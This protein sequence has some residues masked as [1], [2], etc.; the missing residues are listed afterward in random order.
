M[1][2]AVA[3]DLGVGGRLFDKSKTSQCSVAQRPTITE[4]LFVRS[5]VSSLISTREDGP[6]APGDGT[7]VPMTPPLEDRSGEW[8]TVRRL[9]VFTVAISGK[10]LAFTVGVAVFTVAHVVISLHCGSCI[11]K[12]SGGISWSIDYRAGD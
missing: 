7:A 10:H 1:C 3:V 12:H 8:L 11:G 4:A 5:F 9:S 2:S 6:S